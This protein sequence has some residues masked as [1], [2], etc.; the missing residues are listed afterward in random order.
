MRPTSQGCAIS[1]CFWYVPQSPE[2]DHLK[3]FGQF[4]QLT[5]MIV[6][7]HTWSS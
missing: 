1:K 7:Y 5:L 3:V 6:S 4:L 2:V